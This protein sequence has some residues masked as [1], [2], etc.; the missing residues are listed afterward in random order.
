MGVV[1][2][3]EIKKGESQIEKEKRGGQIATEAR[4]TLTGLGLTEMRVKR[5]AKAETGAKQLRKAA[6]GAGKPREVA[7]GVEEPGKAAMAGVEELASLS[8][9]AFFSSLVFLSSS[10]SLASRQ[11]FFL[12]C[13]KYFQCICSFFSLLF[14]FLRIFCYV[15]VVLSIRHSFIDFSIITLV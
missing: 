3:A 4:I 1:W 8:L 5:P 11:A 6:M 7:T 13:D 2:Q 14:F 12:V 9:P 10:A 15:F